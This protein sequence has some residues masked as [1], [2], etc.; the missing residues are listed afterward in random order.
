MKEPELPLECRDEILDI[1]G[2]T[3]VK[4]R[5]DGKTHSAGIWFRGVCRKVH[6]VSYAAGLVGDWLL[7]M[8]YSSV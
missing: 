3:L 6:D 8:T 5:L 7:A 2:V 1:R 4:A